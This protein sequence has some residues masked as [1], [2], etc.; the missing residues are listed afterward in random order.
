VSHVVSALNDDRKSANG[1]KA[2]LLGVAYK[3]NISDTRETPAFVVWRLLEVKRSVVSFHDPHVAVVEDPHSGFGG[4]R[5]EVFN[6]E[7]VNDYDVIVV[8]THHKYG[9]GGG[10]DCAQV[11]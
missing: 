4:K 11:N 5:S 7:T 8:I 1:A 6:E 2:L 3:A 9:G 10:V